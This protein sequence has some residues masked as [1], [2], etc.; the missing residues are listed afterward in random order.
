MSNKLQKHTLPT[1]K[2]TNR[3]NWIRP[4]ITRGSTNHGIKI[5][6]YITN[7]TVEATGVTRINMN[8]KKNQKKWFTNEIRAFAAQKKEAYIMYR[9]PQ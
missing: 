5:K 6:S 4:Y 3:K 9:V 7:S 1:P 8:G 2:E